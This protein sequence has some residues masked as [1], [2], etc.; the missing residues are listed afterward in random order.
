M[1]SHSGESAEIRYAVDEHP[2]HLLAA[3]LGFQVV[4][5][6]LAGIVLTPLIVLRTAGTGE[7]YTSWVVFAALC[8]CGITTIVQARPIGPI[9]AG[10]VLYM[11]TSGA[12]MAVSVT[13][14]Q[15]ARESL[16]LE[17]EEPFTDRLA[18]AESNVSEAGNGR[19]LFRA[20]TP[21]PPSVP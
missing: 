6:I 10:Y 15:L 1:A 11:G 7:E 21:P 16:G 3:G 4:V 14:V 5:L 13:A 8:V 9:G 2:P 12:F 17:L 18:R 20:I 19:D